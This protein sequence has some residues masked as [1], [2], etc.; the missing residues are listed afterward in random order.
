MSGARSE[1]TESDAFRPIPS[2]PF[3]AGGVGKRQPLAGCN[4]AGRRLVRAGTGGH[5]IGVAGGQPRARAGTAG[6]DISGPTLIS[7]STSWILRSR[8]VRAP[9]RRRSGL[10]LPSWSKPL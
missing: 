7:G 10:S 2:V 4:G 1:E 8:P 9:A 5:L 6:P 3:S